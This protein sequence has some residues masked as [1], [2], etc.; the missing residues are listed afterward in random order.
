MDN[1]LISTLAD[2]KEKEA[3]DIVQRRLIAGEDPES[4]LKDA[5][6]AVAIVGYRCANGGYS[7]PDLVRSGETLKVITGMAKPIPTN[8]TVIKHLF[9]LVFG[10]VA[11]G[12]YDIG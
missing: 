2:L 4:I 6:H 11:G 1:K 9:K 7:I 8:G 12:F 10:T 3:L 5:R